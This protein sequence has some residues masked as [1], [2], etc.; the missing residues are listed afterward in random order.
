[1]LDTYV[2]A[3]FCRNQ[4]HRRDI[5]SW[6]LGTVLPVHV[7]LLQKGNEECSEFLFGS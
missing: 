4:V 2:Y 7:W 5:P 1:M 6:Q 3:S